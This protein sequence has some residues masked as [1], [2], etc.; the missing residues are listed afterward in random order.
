MRLFESMMEDCTMLDK[1]SEPDGLGGF[2][3]EW[4]DGAPFKAAVVKNNSME[5]KVAEKQG[6]T[7]LYQVTVP[8]GTPLEYHDVFRRESDGAVFRITSNVKDSETPNA[9]TFQ[10]G[11]ASAERWELP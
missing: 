5:A 7:E 1:R 6:V 10:F 8:K 3:T 4:T 11:Q 9:A 2:T